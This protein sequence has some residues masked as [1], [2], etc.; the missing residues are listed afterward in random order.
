MAEKTNTDPR[1]DNTKI[2]MAEWY[3]AEGE[4]AYEESEW[5][6]VVYED[7]QGVIIGDRSGEEIENWASKLHE[8]ADELREQ[9]FAVAQ[10]VL[11]EDAH[12]Y[13][14]DADLI[15]FDRMEDR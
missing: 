11:G 2:K 10:T 15:V 5:H 8:D 6:Y 9:F 14:E 3:E 4:E 7:E 12:N 1:T 13:A